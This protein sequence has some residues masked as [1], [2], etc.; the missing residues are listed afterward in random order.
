MPSASFFVPNS[1]A[2]RLFAGVYL[3]FSA[4]GVSFWN[5]SVVSNTT[6]LGL[7]MMFYML[8]IL[9]ITVHFLEK[10]KK[11]ASITVFALAAANAAFIVIPMVSDI[12]FYD[13]WLIWAIV[14]II[15]NTV[16]CACI[17]KEFIITKAELKW[18]YANLD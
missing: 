1:C 3:A 9:M 16:I 18:I 15:A 7:S 2:I 10:T 14:Q 11:I 4:E 5:E 12:F 8:F 13:T 17:V 6:I